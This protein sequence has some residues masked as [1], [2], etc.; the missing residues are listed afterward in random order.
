MQNKLF[1]IF[2]S[3]HLFTA[4]A[5]TSVIKMEKDKFGEG[6]IYNTDHIQLEE[7]T[8]GD[9]DL[10][11]QRHESSSGND[12]YTLRVIYVSGDG[13]FLRPFTISSGK[14]LLLNIDGSVHPLY[15]PDGGKGSGAKTVGVIL[16]RWREEA[17]YPNISKSLL[18]KV[19]Q[20]KSI[21]IKLIGNSG[22]TV[23][24]FPE[25]GKTA[26]ENLLNKKEIVNLDED[27][28]NL[29]EKIDKKS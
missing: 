13:G 8:N 4:C 24:F 7:E 23:G 20:A 10:R 19:S 12:K 16:A 22:E 27:E 29:D 5:T 14:S 26:V 2:F 9:I 6:T 15:S 18:K 1:L 3:L 17:L 28:N 25:V 21:K 11:I